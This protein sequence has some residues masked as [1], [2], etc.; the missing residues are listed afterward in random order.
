MVGEPV[1]EEP[2]V[3]ADYLPEVTAV[4]TTATIAVVATASALL[5]K[6][7]ADILLRL[8]KPT[9]KQIINKAKGIVGNG[10]G[11]ISVRER[12]IAQ[13]DRN[14]AIRDMKKFLKK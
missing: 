4:S 14:K 10:Q 12:M 11:Q 13:R 6:P 7:L 9:I 3:I 2:I 8:L 5:A 1:V